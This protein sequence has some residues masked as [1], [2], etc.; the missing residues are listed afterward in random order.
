MNK[1][2]KGVVLV[3]VVVFGIV[4]LVGC[5]KFNSDLVFSK[6]IIVNM[7]MFGDKLKNYDV[8]IKWVNKE[9]YKIYKNINLKMN[10]IGW[11]DYE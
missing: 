1:F 5:G 9:I 10:F 8:M 2:V 3:S 6:V 11:G 4:V 7:Y